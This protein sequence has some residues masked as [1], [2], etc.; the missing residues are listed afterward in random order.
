MV[1]P[2]P[3][4]L[5]ENKGIWKSAGRPDEEKRHLQNYKILLI[6]RENLMFLE[7]KTVRW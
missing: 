7:Q 6:G 1:T 3:L 2:Y 5:W 4:S